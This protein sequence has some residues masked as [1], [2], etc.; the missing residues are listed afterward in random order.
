MTPESAV[1]LAAAP[2]DA[3]RTD[4][5]QRIL[6]VAARLFSERGFAGT[7][8]RDIA[9][10]LGVTKAALY[11]HFPSKDAILGELVAQPLAAVRAVLAEPHRL[12][13]RAGREVFIRRAVDAL[14]SCGPEMM[15]VFR[16]PKLL[17]AVDAEVEDSGIIHSVAA[18]LAMGLS[19]VHRLSDVA[20]QHMVR[21][22][23]AVAAGEA[24]I[25]NWRV[26]YPDCTHFSDADQEVI[27]RL[28]VAT[29][30]S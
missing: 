1:V 3:R 16:D 22:I 18:T 26:V 20:P 25:D 13:D 23:A 8:I 17:A 7:S 30:E 10:A 9:D 29:L 19:G 12:T 4:T 15:A 14:S 11:Y 2:E 5:R 28:I 6:E 24:A 21:A 27:V